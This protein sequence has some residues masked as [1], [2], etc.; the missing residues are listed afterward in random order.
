MHWECFLCSCE[1]RSFIIDYIDLTQMILEKENLG[2]FSL[3]FIRKFTFFNEN[4]LVIGAS[5]LE[6]MYSD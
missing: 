3:F 4:I 1:V 5:M 6:Y 2:Y